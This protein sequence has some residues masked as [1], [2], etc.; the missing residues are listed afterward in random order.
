M[1]GV[2]GFLVLRD[3]KSWAIQCTYFYSYIL[4][5][6]LAALCCFSACAAGCDISQ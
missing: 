6:S 2:A 5:N 4:P 1:V 3:V